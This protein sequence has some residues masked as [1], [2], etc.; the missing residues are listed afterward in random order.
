MTPTCPPDTLSRGGSY[1]T[2][3]MKGFSKT[4]VLVGLVALT[5]LLVASEGGGKPVGDPAA[6]PEV[7]GVRLRVFSLQGRLV[8]DSGFRPGWTVQWNLQTQS[9]AVAANGVY[10]FVITARDREGR[11]LSRIGKIVVLR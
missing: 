2:G 10:L 7:G 9:G 8:Y 1:A 6:D 11:L 4:V 3:I 5:A